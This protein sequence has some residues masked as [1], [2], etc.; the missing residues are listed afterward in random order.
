MYPKPLLLALLLCSLANAQ[1]AMRTSLSQFGITWRFDK[2]YRTGQFANGDYWAIG[3]VK[4][5]GILPQSQKIG[6]RTKHGSML[7][8]RTL[9]RLQG[10]DSGMTRSVAYSA[11]MNVALGVSVLNPLSKDCQTNR[12][13]IRRSKRGWTVL[14]NRVD[15]KPPDSP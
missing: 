1:P 10:Y 6:G 4:I 12:R 8:P 9:P 15:L 3:P 11:S 7:N 14:G 13:G 2:E 5:I